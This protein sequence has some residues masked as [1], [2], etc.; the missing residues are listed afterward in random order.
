MQI[1]IFQIYKRLNTDFKCKLFLI[2]K[3]LAKFV[4]IKIKVEIKIL[5][6][7]RKNIYIKIVQ[8]GNFLTYVFLKI[9][10]VLCHR[11]CKF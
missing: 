7:E 5:P 3:R 6:M 2:K 9:V 1:L 10:F 8:M 4:I 11:W